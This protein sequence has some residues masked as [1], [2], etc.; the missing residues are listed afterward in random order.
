MAIVSAGRHRRYRRLSSVSVD[1]NLCDDYRGCLQK[2]HSFRVSSC[3]P[4]NQNGILSVSARIRMTN[5]NGTPKKNPSLNQTRTLS[6]NQT[7]RMR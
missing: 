2:K 6:R 4:V 7:M 3:G 1:L 5:Q